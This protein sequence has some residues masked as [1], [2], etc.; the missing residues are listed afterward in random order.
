MIHNMKWWKCSLLVL[1]VFLSGCASTTPEA[2]PT[3]TAISN[4]SI[5]APTPTQVPT[6]YGWLLFTAPLDKYLNEL[7]LLSPDGSE[8]IPL[9]L[10]ELDPSRPSWSPNWQEITFISS[11]NIFI[12]NLECAALA[13]DCRD[14]VINITND[15][16]NYYDAPAWSADGTKIAF[17]LF[18]P[19]ESFYGLE[20]I[21]TI[22][23]DGSELTMLPGT[24]SGDSPQWIQDDTHIGYLHFLF[25]NSR[26][27]YVVNQEGTNNRLFFDFPQEYNDV[28]EW[29]I[30]PNGTQMAISVTVWGVNL[31]R[32]PRIALID[33]NGENFQA[34][35]VEAYSAVWSPDG[36]QLAF[37]D[38]SEREY[39]P[40]PFGGTR[41]VPQSIQL[42]NLDTLETETVYEGD[43]WDIAWTP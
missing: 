38:F 33:L 8:V 28:G 36:S 17:M 12:L 24:S 41:L 18:V 32:W 39:R 27:F 9:G 29:H 30:S 19:K 15:E 13:R 4:T 22:N 14:E 31:V 16:F 26:D 34:F 7:Y 5:P 1:S 43:V 37:V 3:D 25:Q 40:S 20:G 21:G 42:L 35:E 11:N 10:S 2:I 6:H 23:V